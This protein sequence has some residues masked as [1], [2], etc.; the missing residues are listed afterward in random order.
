VVCCGDCG[1]CGDFHFQR[2]PSIAVTL[3]TYY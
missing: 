2:L 3:I 1:D